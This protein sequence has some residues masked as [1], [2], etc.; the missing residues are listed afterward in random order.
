MVIW[1]YIEYWTKTSILNIEKASEYINNILKERFDNWYT[2]ERIVPKWISLKY[3][4]NTYP[5][6]KFALTECSFKYVKLRFINWIYSIDIT[7]T[8]IYNK[9]KK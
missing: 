7:I 1:F 5:M 2:I 8:S 9:L 3:T 6:I 4:S